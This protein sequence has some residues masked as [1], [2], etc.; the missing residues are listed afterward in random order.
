MSQTASRPF[1]VLVVDDEA[2]VRDLLCEY[3]AQRGYDV[4]QR[5]D[6]GAA[7]AELAANP[8]GY[9]LVVTD[10]QMPGIDGLGV[11]KAARDAAPS[12]PV[13]IVTGHP[14]LESAAEAI[15]LGAFDYLTKPFSLQQLDTVVRWAVEQAASGARVSQGGSNPADELEGV[16]ARLDSLEARVA[17]LEGLVARRDAP[18]S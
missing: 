10:L 2:E 9:G 13:I 12:P 8:D 3:F 15:R 5:A 11:L 16:R 6:G 7:V 1:R 17:W 14:S 4:Q 18:D